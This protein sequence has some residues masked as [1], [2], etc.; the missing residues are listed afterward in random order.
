[1]MLDHAYPNL[2]KNENNDLLGLLNM[3]YETLKVLD[4]YHTNHP[5]PST[6]VDV[7]QR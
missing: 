6:K 2:E 7:Y 1:M 5:E 4:R 3:D